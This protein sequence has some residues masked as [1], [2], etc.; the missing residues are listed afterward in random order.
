MELASL[1]WKK[2][3]PVDLRS[4]ASK[5]DTPA[6][7][8]MRNKDGA[9]TQLTR[10]EPDQANRTLGVRLAPN[11]NEE[12]QFQ[13]MRKVA[14]EWKD[15]IRTGH[16]PRHLAWRSWQTSIMKTLEYPLSAMP[17]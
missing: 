5:A 16:L 12:S 4:Y 1:I 9:R 11:G 8:T 6:E 15:Q 13:Y 10:L 14:K 7:L 3:R 2:R 17:F